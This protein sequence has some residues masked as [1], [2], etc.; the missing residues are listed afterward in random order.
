[1]GL[2]LIFRSEL[3]AC[4][5]TT[6]TA[7]R[8]TPNYELSFRFLFSLFSNLTTSSVFVKLKLKGRE[9]DP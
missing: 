1:M 3:P 5:I 2:V 6:C 9:C 7:G 4:Q 8:R